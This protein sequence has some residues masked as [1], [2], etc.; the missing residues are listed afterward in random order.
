[1]AR[2]GRLWPSV[3]HLHADG[4]SG[5]RGEGVIDYKLE[6]KVDVLQGT[7]RCARPTSHAQPLG[8]IV[9]AFGA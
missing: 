4:P 3:Q 2:T 1:M 5:A 8:L 7:G 9:P 6:R